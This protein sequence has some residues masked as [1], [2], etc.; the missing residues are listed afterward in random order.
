MTDWPIHVFQYECAVEF[1]G[2]I[3]LELVTLKRLASLTVSLLVHLRRLRLRLPFLRFHQFRIRI[4]VH[5]R[6]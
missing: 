5:V 1:F 6:L 2:K 4:H 3:R